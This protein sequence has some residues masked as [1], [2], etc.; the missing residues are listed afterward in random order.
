MYLKLILAKEFG[1]RS[2]CALCRFTKK[3]CV[4]CA[5]ADRKYKN[6][7]ELSKVGKL[8]KIKSKKHILYVRK[9]QGGIGNEREN[10]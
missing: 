1:G 3:N 2:N 4:F 8:L 7:K 10:R 9:K 6:M 5:F